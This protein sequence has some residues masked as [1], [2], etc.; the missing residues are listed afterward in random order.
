MHDLYLPLINVARALRE[1][2]DPYAVAETIVGLA[3]RLT[4]KDGEVLSPAIVNRLDG[5]QSRQA[6][7]GERLDNLVAAMREVA[8]KD[9]VHPSVRFLA[10]TIALNLGGPSNG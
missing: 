8:R 9:S 2:A 1:G 3:E 5:L 7:D 4:A 6:Y 10:D